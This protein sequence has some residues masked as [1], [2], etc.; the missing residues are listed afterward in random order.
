[1]ELSGSKYYQWRDGYGKA[2]EHNVLTPRDHWLEQT[3]TQGPLCNKTVGIIGFPCDG[4]GI[5]FRDFKGGRSRSR[6][7]PPEKREAMLAEYD[8]SGMTGAAVRE[9]CRG[10]VF[11]ANVLV[12]E[13]AQ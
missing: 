5:W 12:A 6:S 10:E 3:G 2:N 8:R 7:E 9:I 13:A 4:Y 1:M 11:D